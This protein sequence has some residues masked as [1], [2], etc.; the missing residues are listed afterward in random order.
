MTCITTSGQARIRCE[1]AAVICAQARPGLQSESCMATLKRAAD[2]A[3]PGCATLGKC[4]EHGTYPRDA[5]RTN[6]PVRTAVTLIGTKMPRKIT[7]HKSPRSKPPECAQFDVMHQSTGRLAHTAERP[8]DSMI[9]WTASSTAA[10]QTRSSPPRHCLRRA[11]RVD[12]P[13]CDSAVPF[14]VRAGTA[15]PG[16]CPARR[17]SW[18][19]PDL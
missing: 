17:P 5:R 7:G 8:T 15:F 4:R 2:R 6:Q 10:L 16:P 3:A 1:A 12:G 19:P 18:C 14:P 13:Q 9:G 11:G